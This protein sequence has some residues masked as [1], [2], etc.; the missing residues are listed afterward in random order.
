[1]TALKL[2]PTESFLQVWGRYFH[3]F[4]VQAFLSTQY[5]ITIF[6]PKQKKKKKSEREG[7]MCTGKGAIHW[8]QM[9]AILLAGIFS[10]SQS[11]SD[12]VGSNFHF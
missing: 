3:T 12:S 8:P 4:P 9:T 1:M 2:S 5:A 10:E 6:P 7:S 11:F